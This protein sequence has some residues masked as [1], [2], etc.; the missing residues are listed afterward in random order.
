MVNKENVLFEKWKNELSGLIPDGVVDEKSWENANKRILFLLR[1][2]NDCPDGFDERHYLKHYHSENEKYIKS[3]TID[4]IEL[5]AFG[6]QK[7]PKILSWELTEKELKNSEVLKSIVLVNIKKTT[8][9]N[10][11]DWKNF[12]EYFANTNNQ[13][14]IKEQLSIYLPKTDIVICGGTAY[15]L[16][17][18]YPDTLGMNKWKQT[19]RG[20]SYCK[21]K[22]TIY[23]DYKHP[24][25]RAPRNIMYYSLLDAVQEIYNNNAV[26]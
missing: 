5:W 3:P 26:L 8:G 20:I 6:I 16:S 10:I 21:S 15:Y 14:K 7:L 25:I 12:E 22:N 17:C 24:N 2:V 13:C 1:E 23:I 18:L 19:S 9:G 4:C 11:V